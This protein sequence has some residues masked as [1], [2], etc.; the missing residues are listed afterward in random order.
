[1]VAAYKVGGHIITISIDGDA[2]VLDRLL[3]SFIPFKYNADGDALFNISVCNVLSAIP[4]KDCHLVRDVDTGNGITRVQKL[5]D[6]GYQFHVH[7]VLGIECALI[8][9]SPGFTDCRCMIQGNIAMRRFAMNNSLM[10]VYAF[11]GA[12]HDTLLVHASVIRHKGVAYAFTAP[13]GT[14]KSTHVA[15]WMRTVE[16][17]DIVNDDNPI[18]RIEEGRPILYGSPW[19]G[20]TP[21]YRNIRVP[22]GALMQIKRDETNYV[23]ELPPL[24]SF[25]VLLTACSSMKWDETI[26]QNVCSTVSKLVESIKVAELHCLPDMASALVCKKYLEG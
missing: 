19:S 6:G 9:A 3:P 5:K 7:D 16:E 14:G 17:C 11:S 12:T 1:M 8:I 21:C 25:S 18:F 23:K 24:N 13:S 26:F 22:L 4:D 15:N 20:K 2:S 10:L